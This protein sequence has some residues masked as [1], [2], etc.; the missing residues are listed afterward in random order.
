MAG[1]LDIYGYQ[2]KNTA[3]ITT[4]SQ[5]EQKQNARDAAQDAKIK[6]NYDEN[7]T[8]QDEIDRNKLINDIQEI[9]I[10]ELNDK[11]EHITSGGTITDLDMGSW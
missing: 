1:A 10:N 2:D 7:V 6:Y 5:E 11:I 3:L 8:Q 4:K 9:Q